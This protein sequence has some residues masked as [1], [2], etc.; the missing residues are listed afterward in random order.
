MTLLCQ[1][2]E[3]LLALCNFYRSRNLLSKQQMFIH[4][5]SMKPHAASRYVRDAIYS[6]LTSL[7][8]IPVTSTTALWH[9]TNLVKDLFSED[10]NWEVCTIHRS[11]GR[12]WMWVYGLNIWQQ[13]PSSRAQRLGG[14]FL[15]QEY[16][17]LFVLCSRTMYFLGFLGDLDNIIWPG[18]TEP[19]EPATIQRP[20]KRARITSHLSAIQQRSLDVAEAS[21]SNDAQVTDYTLELTTL[22]LSEMPPSADALQE[23]VAI[24]LQQTAEDKKEQ[25]N[26][27]A[28]SIRTAL[29]VA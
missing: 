3:K 21:G 27:A 8:H 13:I 19:A 1:A 22:K 29:Y 25:I 9:L 24:L 28:T 16:K 14:V 15:E 12:Q 10:P 17:L 11:K 18:Q 26:A 4:I 20:N 7:V 6:L 23:H 5:E 2:R